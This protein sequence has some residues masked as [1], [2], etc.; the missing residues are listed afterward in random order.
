MIFCYTRRMI[1]SPLGILFALASAISWGIGDFSGGRAARK[2]HQF[3][4]LVIASALGVILL[5][6]SAIAWGEP[7]PSRIDSAWA[8][9]AG[10]IGIFGVA[11]L[12]YG[13]SL[14]NAVIVAPTAAVVGGITPV[15]FGILTQGLPTPNQWIGFTAGLIGIA[16]VA[17]LSPAL[18][19]EKQKGLSL[20][21]ISG[22]CFGGFF[23][24]IVQV[25]AGSIFYP[26]VISKLTAALIALIMTR[27]MRLAVPSIV[28]N[29]AALIAGTLDAA[30]NVF[31]LLAKNNAR[32]DVVSILASMYPAVTVALASFLL[33][34]KV[35][36]EQWVGV[37]LCVIAVILIAQ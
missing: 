10:L 20:G 26:L 33:R 29:P 35:S 25:R 27:R 23:I 16:F 37:A 7:L 5:L 8:L 21:V 30:G 1:N 24:F 31:Y 9:G 36:R 32:L 19:H 14:G 2:Q 17:G 3:Q 28:S 13:L 15:I 4:A 22:L 34:E 12:Y 18:L 6:I 11:A